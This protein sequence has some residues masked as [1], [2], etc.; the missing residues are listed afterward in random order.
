MRVCY[1]RWMEWKE[2]YLHAFTT[3]LLYISVLM[4]ETCV[5]VLFMHLQNI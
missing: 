3:Y 1:V 5:Y 4:V 2:R